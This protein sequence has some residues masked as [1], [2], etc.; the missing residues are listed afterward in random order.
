MGFNPVVVSAR[1][2]A[3]PSR[4][5]KRGL[6]KLVLRREPGE[7]ASLQS[8]IEHPFFTGVETVRLLSEAAAE[9]DVFLSY[10]NDSD[11]GTAQLLYRLLKAKG[12]RVNLDSECLAAG[13]DWEVG[14]CDGLVKSRCFVPIQ[15]RA[16]IESRFAA[17]NEASYCDNVL[18]EH[19]LAVELQRRG[20]LER[21]FPVLLGDATAGGFAK[22]VFTRTAS[23]SP[24]DQVETKLREHLDRQG[25]GEPL[26]TRP[27]V[28]QVLQS[29]TKCQGG[30]VEGT[31]TLESLLEG[32]ADKVQGMVAD[33]GRGVG[34][35][36]GAS[37]GA[38]GTR[39]MR[40]ALLEQQL[41]DRDRQ[42]SSAHE[43]M[44]E[45]LRRLELDS[46]RPV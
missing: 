31:G 30:K 17:L 24:V 7:R 9:W 11:S 29:I 1:L 42:L 26:E 43:Q 25:L 34:A 20:L 35:A 16:A 14:F 13:L 45:L 10:R 40:I 27:N 12:L 21:V 32:I 15:S 22:Y 19:R 2:P 38:F 37:A 4:A 18:L 46:V 8:I 28:A 39:E 6:L 5:T 44:A 36:G 41:R 3:L 23:Q 33:L